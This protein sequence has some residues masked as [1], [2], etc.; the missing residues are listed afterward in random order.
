MKGDFGL[1]EQNVLEA[2]D[3]AR[4]SSKDHMVEALTSG[5]PTEVL[6]TARRIYDT[7]RELEARGIS[8]KEMINAIRA[9]FPNVESMYWLL[10]KQPWGYL[11]GQAMFAAKM[12]EEEE[13]K[14]GPIQHEG[15][16]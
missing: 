1:S 10:R 14:Y 5:S 6:A 12:L 11:L 2:A 15:E 16:V 8:R 3:D 4:E 13:A 9:E 7:A